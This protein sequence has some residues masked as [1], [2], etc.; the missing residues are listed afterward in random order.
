[1][2]VKGFLQEHRFFLAING[3][4]SLIISVILTQLLSWGMFER[5]E[6]A[7]P[8]II[9]YLLVFIIL[10]ILVSLL[11]FTGPEDLTV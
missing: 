2:G 7:E 4:F 6:Y 11:Y 8:G 9:N 3:I 10:F 1:M 5:W